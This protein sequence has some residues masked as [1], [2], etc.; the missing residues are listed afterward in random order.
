MSFHLR[1]KNPQ[2]F[3]PD[4]RY[5]DGLILLGHRPWD[6]NVAAADYDALEHY[7]MDHV[8]T[9]WRLLVQRDQPLNPKGQAIKD[10]L[11]Q[12]FEEVQA[13]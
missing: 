1:L 11:I 4:I 8:T 7:V 9:L 10:A 2:Q 5:R 13:C 6:L 3:C 12:D